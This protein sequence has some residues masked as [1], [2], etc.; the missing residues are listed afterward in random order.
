MNGH[1]RLVAYSW[2]IGGS[3]VGSMLFVASSF[4][5]IPP[6]V[7]PPI[8]TIGWAAGFVW[9]PGRTGSSSRRPGL[10][11]F[12]SASRVQANLESRWSPYYLV[13]YQATAY[14]TRVF[15]NSGFHQFGY[16]FAVANRESPAET[17]AVAIAKW[18][19]PYQL[20]RDQH[21]R[22]NPDSVMVLVRGRAT[23]WRSRCGMGPRTGRGS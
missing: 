3:L 11:S 7:W 4:G 22:R 15:V 8:V 14:G 12:G 20:Y 5:G 2:D 10:L 9:V 17:G 1:E 23:T 6:W 21:E 16:N 13:Q 18:D 19:V